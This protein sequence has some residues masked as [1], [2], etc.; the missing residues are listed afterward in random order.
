MLRNMPFILKFLIKNINLL[1]TFVIWRN[2]AQVSGSSWGSRQSGV[3]LIS[4]R[5]ASMRNSIRSL[6]LSSSNS[7]SSLEKIK[8]NTRD[9]ALFFF[10]KK[11]KNVHCQTA[12]VKSGLWSLGTAVSRLVFSHCP[13][14]NWFPGSGSLD[15][16]LPDSRLQGLARMHLPQEASCDSTHIRIAPSSC[17]GTDPWASF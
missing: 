4:S 15:L 10:Q 7:R 1:I 6:T 17:A 11:K 12:V 5:M 8:V 14:S 16:P 2:S 13:S 3:L 9:E